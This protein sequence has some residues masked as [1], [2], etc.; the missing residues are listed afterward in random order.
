MFND[1]CN[2]CPTPISSGSVTFS[3]QDS[4]IEHYAVTK[5]QLD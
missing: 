2:L 1:L 5:G 4:D 3:V